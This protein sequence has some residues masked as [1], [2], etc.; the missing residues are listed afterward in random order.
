MEDEIKDWLV[1]L[2]CKLSEEDNDCSD[3]YVTPSGELVCW[4]HLS[5]INFSSKEQLNEYLQQ[6]I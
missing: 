4:R 1:E 3:H 6:Q 5:R 2:G